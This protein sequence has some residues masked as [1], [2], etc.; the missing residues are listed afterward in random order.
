MLNR[1]CA[2]FWEQSVAGT[3]GCGVHRIPPGS[4]NRPSI[5]THAH[6]RLE[7]QVQRSLLGVA[8]VGLGI[9]STAAEHLT[10]GVGVLA[11]VDQRDDVIDLEGAVTALH[12]LS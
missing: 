9:R 4:L 8:V 2:H 1:G 6:A 12:G 7:A 10:I 3:K 5:Q 11:A